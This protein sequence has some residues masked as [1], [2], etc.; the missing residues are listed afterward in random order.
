MEFGIPSGSQIGP[1]QVSVATT[2]SATSSQ[3]VRRAVWKSSIKRALAAA[4]D[5][6]LPPIHEE[7]RIANAGESL[8]NNM[9]IR[10]DPRR[11][12]YSRPCAASGGFPIRRISSSSGTSSPALR[13]HSSLNTKSRKVMSRCSADV[14]SQPASTQTP[15]NATATLI[16]GSALAMSLQRWNKVLPDRLRPKLAAD[17]WRPGGRW[18]DTT[19]AIASLRVP[20]R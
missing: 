18:S 10:A 19:R 15:A 13:M 16:T 12:E 3:E 7:P 14:V 9:L 4:S 2:L 1:L 8:L 6:G 11:T 17:R 5:S 20:L